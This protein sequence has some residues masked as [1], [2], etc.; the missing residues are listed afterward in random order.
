M[1]ERPA[2]RDPCVCGSRTCTEEILREHTERFTYA[3]VCYWAAE[4]LQQSAFD[5]RHAFAHHLQQLGSLIEMGITP[6]LVEELREE[7]WIGLPVLLDLLIRTFE[8][9]SSPR[10]S[11]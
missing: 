1:P 3:E 7:K 9:P 5:D 2:L 4:F 6:Q 8:Y 11:S 10:T